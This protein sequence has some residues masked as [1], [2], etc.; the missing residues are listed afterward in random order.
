M[1]SSPTK[2]P[3]GIRPRGNKFFVDVSVNGKRKTDTADTLQEAK[4]KQV[5]IRAALLEGREIT[6]GRQSNS[7]TVGHAF[8]RT[9]ILFWEGTRSEKSSKLNGEAAVSFFGRDK[10]L[11]TLDLNAL[12]EWVDYLKSIGNSNA[13]INRKMAALS[14]MMSTAA[15]RGGLKSRPKMPRFKESV[16][17]IRFFTDDEEAK[18]LGLARKW[19]LED[20]WDALVVLIDTGLRPSEL[21]RIVPRDQSSIGNRS[22]I[23]VWKTKADLPRT[24]PLTTRADQVLTRRAT[25]AEHM[26]DKLFKF[27]PRWLWAQFCRIRDH[28][29]MP[30]TL[31][32]TCRHTCASRLV[33]RGV[34]LPV[35]QKWMGH[36]TIQ[37]TMRYAHLSPTDLLGAV[38]ALE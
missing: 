27:K 18:I 31:I 32:Y 5:A 21:Y 9:L 33:Q 36:K 34:S 8:D 2:C 35:V 37:V 13:T 6:G 3:R 29:N 38:G 7:W 20:V 30:D 15:D 12:D 10:P 28:L 26:D 16:G 23:S 4:D 1:S 11:H 22:A 19:G 17:R 14:K 24:V 25:A